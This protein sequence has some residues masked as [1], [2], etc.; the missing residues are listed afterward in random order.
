MTRRPL[1]DIWAR[2]SRAPRL[3]GEP[4]PGVAAPAE[5]QMGVVINEQVA[6][7]AKARM[8]AGVRRELN[9]RRR[10]GEDTAAATLAGDSVAGEA[11]S[12]MLRYRYTPG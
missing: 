10:T 12:G 1:R 2:S 5:P 9:G 11:S 3:L 8:R 7:H 4:Y 6:L